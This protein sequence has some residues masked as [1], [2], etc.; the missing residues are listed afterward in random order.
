MVISEKG[1]PVLK[2]GPRGSPSASAAAL[3]AALL[4]RNLLD[5]LAN[6][7]HW[8][9]WTTHFG[10]LSGSEPKLDDAVRR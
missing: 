3:G 7:H 6:V 5:I 10:P 1:E 9:P 8:T 4:E 2:R